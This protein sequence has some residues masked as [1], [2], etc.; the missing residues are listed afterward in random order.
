ENQ[1]G[2]RYQALRPLRVEA[3]EV[4]PPAAARLGHQQAGDQKAR[5]DEEEV[6]P[7]ESAAHEGDSTVREQRE[8]QADGPHSLD[9]RPE[10]DPPA[11]PH[12]CGTTTGHRASFAER[13]T[14]PAT[15]AHDLTRSSPVGRRRGSLTAP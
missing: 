14:W 5:D 15:L 3:P 11:G 1:T 10:A 7:D 2:E 9:V 13:M 6:D 8:H 12:L 4:D